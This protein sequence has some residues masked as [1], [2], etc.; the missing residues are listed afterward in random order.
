[1]ELLPYTIGTLSYG[2]AALAF[3]ILTF[4]LAVS[5]RGHPQGVLLV[6]AAA[7]TCAWAAGLAYHAAMDY[8]TMYVLPLLELARDGVWLVFLLRLLSTA[9]QGGLLP[10]AGHV[11][12]LA[13][14]VFA[15]GGMLLAAHVAAGFG[16][17]IL[18]W[19]NFDLYSITYMLMTIAGLVL[20]E[21][22]FRN[23]RPENRWSI[24]FLCF[25]IGGMFAYDLFLFSE[26]MV[27]NQLDQSFWEARGLVN[28]LVVPLIA[29]SA[30]RNPQWSVD[31]FVSR[32]IVFHV[33]TLVVAGIYFLA[34]AVGGYYVRA[35]GGSWGGVVQTLL[36]FGSAVVLLMLLFS[37][38][39][40]AHLKVFLS[41]HFYAYKYDY[42]EQW[43]NVTGAM[44]SDRLG[45]NLR[46]RVLC[47]LANIVDSIGGVLWL[48]GETGQY[49]VAAQWN[50]PVRERTVTLDDPVV[51]FL[52]E[53]QWLVDLD[54]YVNDPELYG[55]LSLPGWITDIP[56]AWVVI[57]LLNGDDL[58][59]FVLL[60]QS[61]APRQIN[62]EDRDLLKTAA[63]Q[64]ASYL[65]LEQAS[66]ALASARQFEAFNRLSAYVVHDLKN[67]LGQLS[68]VAANAKKH[69]RNEAFIDD[70]FATVDNAVNKMQRMLSQLRQDRSAEVA[71]IAAISVKLVPI[72]AEVVRHRAVAR[73]SPS[74]VSGEGG[75]LAVVADHDRLAAVIEHIIQNAQD[76]TP[77]GGRVEVRLIQEN[78]LAVVEIE[79]SGCGMD[80]EF[81]RERLFKP[82]DTT[83]GNAGMGIGAYEC[84]EFIHAL[85]GRVEVRSEVGAGTLFRLHMPVAHQV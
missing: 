75:E 78:G 21:Q 5:W 35:F 24:K 85:G 65:A 30:A 61:R 68:L 66:A 36:L 57:P 9:E 55:D 2:I 20:V 25:G 82:F 48:K 23:T 18:A 58:L 62:W 44:S 32:H 13:F 41:K 84:R 73:P 80:S 49:D 1:M 52:V 47:A 69:R 45:P 34:I 60:I 54:E 67:V 77:E 71:A 3:L 31:I 7:V 15:V 42:R 12:V 83:K 27:V 74:L 70:A 72:L 59:G 11:R 8:R 43:L 53:R 76:A 4:L 38:H 39:V 19:L 26:A 46:L 50:G 16:A 17:P 6:I 29:V 37:G 22:L 63:Q 81:V 10:R 33:T 51:R 64:A 79:D 40:Q 14:I 28:A 56:R